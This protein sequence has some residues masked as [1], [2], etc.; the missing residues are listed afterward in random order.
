MV[1]LEE[2][3]LDVFAD[4]EQWK[5]DKCAVFGLSCAE[6]QACFGERVE[7]AEASLSIADPSLAD[8]YAERVTINRSL[9]TTACNAIASERGRLYRNFQTRFPGK[10]IY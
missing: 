9:Q 7:V 2:P 4:L 1:W 6:Q 3:P 8:L 5:D 10:P